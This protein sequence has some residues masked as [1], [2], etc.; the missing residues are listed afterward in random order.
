[1]FEFI[2]QNGK[3]GEMLITGDFFGDEAT[4]KERAV[5]EFV[6]NAFAYEYITFSTYLTNITVGK[7]IKVNGR[8]WKV[9]DVNI[10]ADP[11]KI[12][13]SIKAE[14]YEN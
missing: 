14:R 2:V 4:A 5:S 9:I 8:S 12:M 6:D 1:M 13:S 11:V 7:I 3:S 10:S